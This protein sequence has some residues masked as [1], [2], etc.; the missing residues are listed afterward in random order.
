MGLVATADFEAGA[1]AGLE[2]AILGLAAEGVVFFTPSET[3]ARGRV[4]EADLDSG[5]DIADERAEEAVGFVVV[6]DDNVFAGTGLATFGG[7]TEALRL[8]GAEFV[9]LV[10]FDDAM[11]LVGAAVELADFF[12][13]VAAAAV[14]VLVAAV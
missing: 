14:L 10:G 8:A 3:E 13:E 2:E 1:A 7:T 12:S 6:D 4:A 11:V 5:G 9:V